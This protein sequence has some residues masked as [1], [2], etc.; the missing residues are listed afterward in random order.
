MGKFDTY[1][2]IFTGLFDYD[3]ASNKFKFQ[4]TD[5]CDSVGHMRLNANLGEAFDM[6]LPID[7]IVDFS[8]LTKG[9]E[10]SRKYDGKL[11]QEK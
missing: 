1:N 7:G 10:I 9:I 4:N 11:V 5:A 6:E 2:K 8:S 3:G